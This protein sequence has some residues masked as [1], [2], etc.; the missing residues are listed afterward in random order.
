MGCARRSGQPG[1][2]NLHQH[3]D[4]ATQ[5]KAIFD[6]W[7][8]FTPMARIG[9]TDEIASVVLFL[10]SDASSLMT[11]SILAADGGYTYR[12]SSCRKA[13]RRCGVLIYF[14]A[15]FLL[16]LAFSAAPGLKRAFLDAAILISLPVAGLRPFPAARSRTENVPNPTSRTS[17]PFLK[18][19]TMPSRT[20]SSAAA[21]ETLVNSASVAI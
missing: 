8:D 20:A 9:E 19:S 6:T 17:S 4:D 11:G 18:V 2:A 21:A 7:M 13:A 14:L 16:R 12:R 10:A 5:N 1:R 3:A 15:D